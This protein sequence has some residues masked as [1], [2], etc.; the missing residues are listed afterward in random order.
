MIKINDED[1]SNFINDEY[2]YIEICQNKRL[3]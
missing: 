2:K 3:L 1:N